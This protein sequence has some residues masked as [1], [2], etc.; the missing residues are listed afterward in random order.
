MKK[1]QSNFSVND[2]EHI[3]LLV[4]VI[5]LY[6]LNTS[7]ESVDQIETSK[8]YYPTVHKIH[9][10]FHGDD[11]S[12]R[13]A[14]TGIDGEGMPYVYMPSQCGFAIALAMADIKKKADISS[15][16]FMSI[17]CGI[18]EKR[19]IKLQFTFPNHHNQYLYF[20]DADTEELTGGFD[21]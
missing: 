11:E 1:R 17:R 3:R 21:K 9:S 5:L 8:I 19:I 7:A 6:S 2:L 15:D 14:A 10:Y 16:E 12:R 18:K 20:F 4:I 13:F